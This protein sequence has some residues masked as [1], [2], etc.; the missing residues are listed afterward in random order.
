MCIG[1]MKTAQKILVGNLKV[2][3]ALGTLDADDRIILKW[4]RESV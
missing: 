4:S 3:K 2:R 1:K